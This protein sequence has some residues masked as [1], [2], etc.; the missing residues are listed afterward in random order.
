MH[1]YNSVRAP[2]KWKCPISL[3]RGAVKS[4][5]A[6]SRPPDRDIPER[7]AEAQP[8]APGATLRHA[9]REEGPVLPLNPVRLP[10]TRTWRERN[11]RPRVGPDK[12]VRSAA[13]GCLGGGV[14][15]RRGVSEAGDSVWGRGGETQRGG[16]GG[17]TWDW[18]RGT[19]RDH[20]DDKEGGWGRAGTS[21]NNNASP[22][23]RE[24]T[25]LNVNSYS[26]EY[27]RGDE[28]VFCLDVSGFILEM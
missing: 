4:S 9:P 27:K 23:H 28:T 6:P 21:V 13:A 2:C 19:G 11:P 25:V 7:A 8:A 5:A 26:K 1:H 22:K 14:S 17:A 3:Q 12:P 15:R 18:Q 24:L 10:S 20:N 16:Q